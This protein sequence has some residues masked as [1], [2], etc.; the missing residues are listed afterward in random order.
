MSLIQLDYDPFEIIVVGNARSLEGLDAW[1]F[2]DQL[3][4][5]PFEEANIS[6][7]RNSGIADSA[8][9]WVA[10]IDDDSAAEPTWLAH[11]G[12]AL[13]EFPKV[14]ALT[15][16]V[17][18]RNGISFQ[19]KSAYVDLQGFDHSL[20]LSGDAPVLAQP[21]PDCAPKTEGTNMAFRRDVLIALG[22]FDPSFQ[23]FLDEP[24]LNMRLM[25]AGYQTCFVP[26]AQVHHGYVENATRSRAR[27][28]TSLVEIGA[29][30]AVFIRKFT[31]EAER[32]DAIAAHR[33]AIK[34]RLLRYLQAG[35][36][37]AIG[38]TRLLQEFE[39][40]FLAGMAREISPFVFATE[41]ASSF[42][43]ID[44]LFGK[45]QMVKKHGF[46]TMAFLKT[47]EDSVKEGQRV[48]VFCFSRTT[49][50]HKVQF[51]KNGFWLHT[52][53]LFGKRERFERIFKIRRFAEL[54]ELE[55]QRVLRLRGFEDDAAQ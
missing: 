1:Q 49:L 3:K 40:G 7:A 16:Y 17:R 47:A 24:D 46:A 39:Q 18:G 25:Q 31:P 29:S 53:G 43:Q 12:D 50:F 22:G 33:E 27:V 30:T 36:L 35:G 11:F 13:N 23:Y 55:K 6:K 32:E 19:R 5:V 4:V 9:D 21:L 37:D 45:M 48:T 15:G 14:A 52:G 28:P 8:G 2:Y 54:V 20:E 44:V 26:M 10:F 41:N 42:K 34:K 38:V 51:V